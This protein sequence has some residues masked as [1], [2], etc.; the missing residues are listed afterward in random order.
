[1]NE[2][3]ISWII[4]MSVWSFAAMGFDKKRAKKRGRRVSEK[5]LWLL[6][7]MGGGIGAYLGMI[8]FKHKTRKTGFR[9]GFLL[10]AAIYILLIIFALGIDLSFINIA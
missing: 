6:A 1:M 5:N 8:F 3:I 2:L 9:I 10:L 7:I 4:F